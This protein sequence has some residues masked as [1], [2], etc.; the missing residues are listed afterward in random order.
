MLSEHK[1]VKHGEQPGDISRAAKIHMRES[2]IEFN[3]FPWQTIN[4][5]CIKSFRKYLSDKGRTVQRRR[6]KREIANGLE[7]KD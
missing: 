4:W 3:V 6:D 5:K 7:D 2:S 1:R